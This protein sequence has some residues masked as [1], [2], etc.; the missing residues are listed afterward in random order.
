MRELGDYLAEIEARCA[1]ATKK[2]WEAR[3]YMR[4]GSRAGV[5]KVIAARRTL[6][7]APHGSSMDNA[8]LA[9]NARTDL[10]RLVAMVKAYRSA[11]KQLTKETPMPHNFAMA[12]E[13]LACS[14]ADFDNYK[15]SFDEVPDE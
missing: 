5:P 15:P 6:M 7:E 3:L 13:L 12:S 2:P 9:A 14:L 1:A 8:E 11:L 4:P 10:P